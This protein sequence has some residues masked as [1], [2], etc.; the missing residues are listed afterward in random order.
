MRL[1]PNG[2]PPVI[3]DESTDPDDLVRVSY[4][5]GGLKVMPILMPAY[6]TAAQQRERIERCW[7]EG[8]IGFDVY[9]LVPDRAASLLR[10]Q[11][12]ESGRVRR[13]ELKQERE[14]MGW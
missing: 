3:V 7:A 1:G 10:R 2:K 4:E 6:M 13:D 5:R 8:P 12:Q 9:R 14:K 11:Q